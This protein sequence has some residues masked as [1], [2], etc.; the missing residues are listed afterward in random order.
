MYIDA[1]CHL[2]KETYGDELGQV[3]Q[4][5]WAANFTHLIAVGA[6]RV[7]EGAK[8]VLTLVTTDPRIFGTIGI[9]PHDAASAGEAEIKFVESAVETAKIVALGE[10]GLDYYYDNS[11][12]EQQKVLF[13]RLLRIA[14]EKNIPAMLHVRDA[15]PDTLK[16]LDE[17]GL[18]KRGGV[19][20]CFTGDVYQARDYVA[21]G[22]YLSIAGVVTFKTAESLREA[23]KATPIERLLLET[24]CPYLA[25]VPYRGK[26]NEP[27][28]M[29][30]TAQVV[31]ELKGLTPDVLGQIC[32]ENTRRI[33]N[34]C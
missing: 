2:E 13:S 28:Y 22:M 16:I 9:H 5:A 27:A 12:R 17:V 33:Y 6:T 18:P 8:E 25:P 10:I 7:V 19:V 34:L 29:V 1:H 4:R 30:Q 14:K 20:H 26:R 21:R 23:V 31:A 3:L 15:H 32:S 11:P 24:D